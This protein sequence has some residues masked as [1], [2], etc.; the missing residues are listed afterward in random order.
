MNVGD[1]VEVI[2]SGYIYISYDKWLEKHAVAHL[3]KWNRGSRRAFNGTQGTI[4]VF[5]PH[6]DFKEMLCLVRRDN[7]CLF[8]IEKRGLKLIESTFTKGDLKKGMAVKHRDG[9]LRFITKD[10]YDPYC[11][12]DLCD[13]LTNG[14]FA[15]SRMDIIEVFE[16]NTIWK[17]EETREISMKDA[18]IE[19]TEKYGQKVKIIG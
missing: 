15:G 13:D 17:R 6:C 19:L 7:G 18:E 12:S 11:G 4:I 16:L 14:G 2:D 5:A 1:R 9:I 3:E 10:G 8:L